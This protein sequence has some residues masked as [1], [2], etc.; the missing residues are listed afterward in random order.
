MAV[1]GELEGI[2]LWLEAALRRHPESASCLHKSCWPG[3]PVRAQWAAAHSMAPCPCIP[4]HSQGNLN[5]NRLDIEATACVFTAASGV[6]GAALLLSCCP[7]LLPPYHQ[8]CASGCCAACCACC[9]CA[10][11]GQEPPCCSSPPCCAPCW[12]ACCRTAIC[13]RL[14]LLPLPVCR[15]GPLRCLLCLV[16]HP[17]LAAMLPW[18]ALP[19]PAP[20]HVLTPSQSSPHRGS[21]AADP[22]AATAAA[23]TVY[24]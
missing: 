14:R 23:P 5:G 21:S 9:C 1:V 20:P 13:R 7:H 22:I 3:S 16:Q 24:N 15:P 17:L 8:Q 18:P 4:L 11:R 6:C 10:C 12:T 2:K 19:C